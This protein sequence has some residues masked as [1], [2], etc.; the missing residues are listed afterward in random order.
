MS[1]SEPLRAAKAHSSNAIALIA[2]GP[3]SGTYRRRFLVSIGARDVVVHVDDLAWVRANGYCATL[4]LRD[5]REYLVRVPL[6][7]LEIELDPD[8]F[9]RVHR[10]AMVRLSELQGLE[11]SASRSVW[12]VLRSGTRIPVS[13]SRRDA[14]IH[15]LGGA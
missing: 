4:V 2:P 11:R 6:D 10:S 7:R 15:A 9:I 5:R 14:L 8:E 1:R 13:R 3:S 12:A